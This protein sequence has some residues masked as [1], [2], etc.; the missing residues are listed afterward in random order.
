MPGLMSSAAGRLE[1]PRRKNKKAYK[2]DGQWSSVR[3]ILKGPCETKERDKTRERYCS[4]AT[5]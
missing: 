1:W 2:D 5:F 4:L 3:A